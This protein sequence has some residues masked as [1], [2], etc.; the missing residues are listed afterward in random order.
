[1]LDFIKN[2][3]GANWKTTLAGLVVLISVS[4]KCILAGGN[5]VDCFTDAWNIAFAAGG[6][7]LLFAGD[8]K[9]ATK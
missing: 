2:L 5:I 6:I 8:G 4:A 9:S 3:F 7:G 1:M